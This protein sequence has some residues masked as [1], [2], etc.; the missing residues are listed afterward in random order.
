MNATRLNKKLSMFNY[1][2]NKYNE[3]VHY[4]YEKIKSK[5]HTNKPLDDVDKII[6]RRMVKAQ[7]LA[8]KYEARYQDTLYKATNQQLLVLQSV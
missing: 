2:M 1:Q 8:N 4:C 7:E 5:Q 3:L 6:Y